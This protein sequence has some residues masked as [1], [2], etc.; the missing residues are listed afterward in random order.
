[1]MRRYAIYFTPAD[2]TALAR[3]GWWWLGRRAEDAAG[4]LPEL[5]LERAWQA[6]TIAEARSY[7]F[8]A[9]L[10]PP[11]RLAEGW[12]AADLR[13][14]LT[15]F[16]AGYPAFRTDPLVLED[17]KGFLALRPAGDPQAIQDLAAVC[18]EQF[19]AFRAPPTEAELQRRLAAP[20]T[21][22]HREL[23]AR[24]GYPYVFDQFRFHMT[25]TCRLDVA[26]RDQ[27][28]AVLA[29]P[30]VPVLAAPVAFDGLTLFEQAG[31]GEPFLRTGVFP[32]GG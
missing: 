4:T 30:L 27:L 14:A 5:G 11:F 29:A 26:E 24:W 13:R 1:M 12:Q 22:R 15:D 25:L 8:H 23:L 18:V 3:F 2:D 10:K 17:L 20:L 7:G 28:R 9:T 21:D 31:P 19:D 6:R 16:A 32:F